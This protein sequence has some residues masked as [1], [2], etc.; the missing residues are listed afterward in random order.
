VAEAPLQLVAIHGF[1]GRA[2]DWHAVREALHALAPAW[3]FDA[4][5]LP[6][7]PGA[8]PA[9]TPQA[10]AHAFNAA[11]PRRGDARR[12]LLGYSLGGRLAVQAALDSPQA[13]DAL[14]LVSAQVGT[15]PPE[16]RSARLE[17]DAEWAAHFLHRPWPELM[18][19]W[20]R[21]PVFAGSGEPVRREAEFDRCALARVLLDWSPARDTA[22]L[23]AVGAL[24]MPLFGYAGARDAKYVQSLT[25]L[26]D[27]G[28]LRRLHTFK[29][30]GHRLPFD[31]P[32][33]LAAAL[34]ADLRPLALQPPAG[35]SGSHG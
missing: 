22:P 26:R 8:Q 7:Q 30:A 1:L 3:G 28:L 10:W 23:A 11:H 12:V 17:R 34:A 32:A 21:Q 2:A 33:A 13:W 20:N 14:A 9:A 19:A 25:H 15:L 4:V 6:L 35:P 16:A 27:I 31:A 29:A 5:E 24:A 18:S